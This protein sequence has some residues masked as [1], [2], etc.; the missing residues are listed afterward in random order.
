MSKRYY[1]PSV[2]MG[3]GNKK[4]MKNYLQL[5]VDEIDI[6]LSPKIEPEDETGIIIYLEKIL[7]VRKIDVRGV[8]IHM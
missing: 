4:C 7:F 8:L 1:I 5:K 2:R 3:F 6:Y